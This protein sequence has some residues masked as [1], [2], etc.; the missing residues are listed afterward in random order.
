MAYI[1]QML[2]FEHAAAGFAPL[3]RRRDQARRLLQARILGRAD[4]RHGRRGRVIMDTGHVA[5]YA[6]PGQAQQ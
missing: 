4:A 2:A 1:D 3:A 6:E 5:R